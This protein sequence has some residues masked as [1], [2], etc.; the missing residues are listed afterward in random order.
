MT[1]PAV[2]TDR[3]VLPEV[4]SALL[5]VTIETGIVNG[6]PHQQAVG[7]FS[8]G[9]VTAAAVHLA[10]PHRVRERFHRLRTLFLVA[11]K[12]DLCLRRGHQH[13]VGRGM[14]AV[15]VGTG[16]LFHIMRTAV[17]GKAQIILVT[18][19]TELVLFKDGQHAAGS[20]SRYG[21]ALLTAPHPPRMLAARSMAGLT[22]QLAVTE[23]RARILANGV[24][25][26]E[27][28]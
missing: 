24:L 2:L 13:R 5:G 11:I 20:K 14:A 26:A 8:V 16:D 10:L 17:P 7:R 18:C 23:W 6:L 27:H 9:A 19:G 28:G 25:A 3:R 22:L 21:R 4:R 1:I 15:T 12:A